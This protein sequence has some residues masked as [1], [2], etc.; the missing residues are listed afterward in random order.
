LML[1]DRLGIGIWEEIPL[2]HFTPETFNLVM[3]RGLPQ[4]MLAEMALRDFNRP[5]VMFHGFANESTGVDERLSAMTTLRDLDRRIDGTRL[6]G[7]AMYGSDPTDPTSAPLDVAGYTFYYGIFYGGPAPEPGT[8]NALLAAHRTYP[9]KPVMILEFGD[10]LPFNGSEAEQRQVFRLTYPAF[11]ANLDLLPAGFIG[12]T[13]WWSL[14]DYWTD[15]PGIAVERFGLF[16]PDGG[17]RAVGAEAKSSFGQVTTPAATAPHV[18]S[19]GQ[20]VPV[21][22]AEPSHFAGQLIYAAVFPC[23]LVGVLVGALLGLRRLRLARLR[24]AT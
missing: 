23:V 20:A 1:A 21:P 11:A 16:K 18:V 15:V 3:Q 12:S 4:Q 2:N 24:A 8:S 17:M 14:E 13:V 5:S 7:Q 22:V 6:T 10:W 9:H 19:G